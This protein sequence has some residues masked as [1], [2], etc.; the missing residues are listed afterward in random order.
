MAEGWQLV[1]FY[2]FEYENLDLNVEKVQADI[3][4]QSI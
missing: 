3:I 1:W 2:P 4:T